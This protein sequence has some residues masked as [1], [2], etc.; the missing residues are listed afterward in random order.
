MEMTITPVILTDFREIPDYLKAIEMITAEDSPATEA[1]GFTYRSTP[2]TQINLN[3]ARA[4]M[5]GVAKG[6]PDYVMK[7]IDALSNALSDWNARV[8]KEMN[9]AVSGIFG[10]NKEKVVHLSNLLKIYE[11]DEKR[12]ATLIKQKG[13]SPEIIE[14]TKVELE[15]TRSRMEEIRDDIR[16]CKLNLRVPQETVQLLN[17]AN[18]NA[19]DAFDLIRGNMAIMF[20]LIKSRTKPT[21]LKYGMNDDE[22]YLKELE[23][24]TDGLRQDGGPRGAA[25]V[26]FNTLISVSTETAA[27]IYQTV[28]INSPLVVYEKSK[29]QDLESTVAMLRKDTKEISK[30]FKELKDAVSAC[31]GGRK[32]PF[33]YQMLCREVVF[34]ATWLPMYCLAVNCC[35]TPTLALINAVAKVDKNETPFSK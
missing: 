14:R 2:D 24:I 16:D 1:W 29:I 8:T 6:S 5:A 28:D 21:H 34:W 31:K 25:P 27:R 10:A 4:Y 23:R 26:D 9:S 15:E 30:R 20:N 33:T 11:K 22:T 19:N 35:L 13:A 17:K 18:G 32:T 12:Y 3:Q 7:C